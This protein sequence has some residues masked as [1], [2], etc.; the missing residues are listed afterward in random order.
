MLSFIIYMKKLILSFLFLFCVLNAFA[1]EVSDYFTYNSNF[2]R[3]SATVS[4]RPWYSLSVGA[5]FDIT[6]H[7]AFGNHIYA[8]RLPIALTFESANFAL[9]PFYYPDNANRASAMGGRAEFTSVIN[10][11][12][13]DNTAVKLR[14]GAGFASQKADMFKNGS[15]SEQETFKQAAYEMDLSFGYFERYFFDITGNAYQYLSGIDGVDALFGVMNQTEIADLG[16][17]DYVFGMPHYS[18]GARI[19]WKSDVSNSDN[20]ISYRYIDFYN[21]DNAHSVLISST[22]RLGFNFYLNLAYNHIFRPGTD[23]DIYTAGAI[24]KF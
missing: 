5:G 7:D 12:D 6:E 20:F 9:T 19:R 8:L 10:R 2:W 15:L 24:L 14:M 21:M 18:A 4:M 16:T 22:M 13:I 1:L 23:A 3:N 17:A 11:N